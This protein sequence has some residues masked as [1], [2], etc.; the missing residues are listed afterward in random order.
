MLN[1]SLCS[2]WFYGFLR[3]VEEKWRTPSSTLSRSHSSSYK[4]LLTFF[5][6]SWSTEWI[7]HLF[8]KGNFSTQWFHRRLQLTPEGGGGWQMTPGVAVIWHLDRK[9][10][11]ENFTSWPLLPALVVEEE[12]GATNEVKEKTRQCN[13]FNAPDLFKLPAFVVVSNGYIRCIH[14]CPQQRF[15]ST[16]ILNCNSHALDFI[17]VT[18]DIL[19]S[20]KIL[21]PPAKGACFPTRWAVQEVR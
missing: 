18:Y 4:V 17:C 5:F 14:V 19:I 15:L 1:S 6:K 8:P 21:E 9:Q 12:H 11:R 10:E 16:L 20:V 7:P 3:I 2:R 13:T